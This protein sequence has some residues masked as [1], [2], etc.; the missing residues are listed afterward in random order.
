MAMR[1][2]TNILCLNIATYM[3]CMCTYKSYIKIDDYSSDLQGMTALFK[4]L[5]SKF[6]YPRFF[7][8]PVNIYQK[9]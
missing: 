5:C 9:N 8:F 2:V 4:Y 7:L 3:M 1:S 6:V